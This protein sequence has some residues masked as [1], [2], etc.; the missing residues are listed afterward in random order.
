MTTLDC[1][2]PSMS[3]DKRNETVTALQALALLNNRLMLTMAK[4]MAARVQAQ[5]SDLSQQIDFAVRLALSRSPTDAE[6]AEL[7]AYAQTHGLVS[8]C[9]VLMNLNEFVFVD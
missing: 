6:R 3:V 1:A 8:V 7:T 4:H 5:T 9:R 2:D